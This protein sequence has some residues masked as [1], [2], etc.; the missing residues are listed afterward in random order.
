LGPYKSIIR[1]W[2]TADL[3]VPRKQRHTARRVWQRLVAEHGARVAE[4][5]VRA[6]VAEVK[7]ELAGTAGDVTVVQ[8]H[9]PGAD[10]E[11][12]QRLSSA[13]GSPGSCWCCSCS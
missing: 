11:V 5:T 3:D 13:R 9:A 7:V 8:E 4:P 10:A 2:L 1:E 12:E 6:F